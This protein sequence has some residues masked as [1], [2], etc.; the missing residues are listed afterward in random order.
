MLAL[1]YSA[2]GNPVDVVAPTEIPTPEPRAGLVRL[3]LAGSPIHNHDLATIRGVY[4]IKPTLPAVAGSEMV[5]TVDAVG[6]GVTG[7][8]A[9]SRVAVITQGAWAQY[10]LAPAAGLVPVPAAIP[11]EI[12]AQLLAMPLSAVVLFDELHVKAGDWIVQNAAGGAVGRILM[13]VAQSAGVNVVNLVRRESA[14]EE[15]RGFGARHVVVT[16]DEKW[17]QRVREIAGGAPIVRAIDSVCDD[18]SL[19]LHALLAPGGEHVVFGALAARALKLDPGALI[20]GQTL[21]RGFWMTALMQQLS[22]Q[23]RIE[24]VGRVFALALAGELPLPVS[25]KHSL[26]DAKQALAQAET[27]GRSGKVLFVP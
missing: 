3:A 9:G 25:S 20:S 1:Q 18:S 13:R 4:G 17:P 12:A 6:D 11:D 21:V 16:G 8:E 23:R 7:V 24:A 5:G 10:A 2:F 22:A 26:R 27:P 14:A 15:L 19:A